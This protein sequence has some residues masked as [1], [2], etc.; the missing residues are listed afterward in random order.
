MV[1]FWF[2]WNSNA[3]AANFDAQLLLGFQHLIMDGLVVGALFALI[4]H[5]RTRQ[6]VK[7]GQQ[8]A[9]ELILVQEKFKLEQELKHQIEIQAQTDYLTGINNRRHFA[10]L[11]EQELA[12]AIR[13]QRP[14]TL[15]V[16]DVDHFK[17]INDSW[18]HA[19]GDLVLQR[20]ALLTSDALRAQ[21][22]FGRTG[23]E[24]FAV[25]LVE[26]EGA[27]AIE[28]AQRLCTSVA[29]ARIAPCDDCIPVSIS[30][31]VAQLKGR[32]IAFNQLLQEAD[33]AMYSAKDAGRNRV[34][35]SEEAL[36]K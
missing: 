23:G 30:I 6:A 17:T 8:S 5:T 12:R 26:T 4:L 18:G 24:E 31:G 13:F 29:S 15:L 3:K 22:L 9:I 14:Y 2:A 27:A 28:A 7:E 20:I 1:V 33:R 34:F 32:K 10:E 21:D 35:V 19:V 36:T 25:V 16:I 11:A